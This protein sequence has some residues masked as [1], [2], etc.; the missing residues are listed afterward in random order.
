MLQLRL[1]PPQA[2]K[3]NRPQAQPLKASDSLRNG[4]VNEEF[5]ERAS[6]LSQQLSDIVQKIKGLSEEEATKLLEKEMGA[7]F[8]QMYSHGKSHRLYG[9]RS[10][11]NMLEEFVEELL[12][13]R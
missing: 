3:A 11:Q 2:L 13:R 8:A 9:S 4:H 12:P 1:A 10:V 6:A 7:I 5:G